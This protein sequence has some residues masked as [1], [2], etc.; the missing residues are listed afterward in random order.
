MKKLI[1]DK[2]YENKKGSNIIEIEE[3]RIK[4]GENNIIK[5]EEILILY[6]IFMI[7]NIPIIDK[8]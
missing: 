2:K 6:A 7:Y 4:K 1:L 3:R 8:I 5:I